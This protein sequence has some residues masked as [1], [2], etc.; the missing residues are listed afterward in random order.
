V[1]GGRAPLRWQRRAK[2]GSRQEVAVA[3]GAGDNRSR[4]GGD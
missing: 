1:G 3:W 2:S 4:G